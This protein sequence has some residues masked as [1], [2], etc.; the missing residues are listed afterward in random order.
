MR[1]RKITPLYVYTVFLLLSIYTTHNPNDPKPSFPLWARIGQPRQNRHPTHN[2]IDP[3]K[4]QL[5]AQ[6]QSDVKLHSR[7]LLRIT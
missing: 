2:P 7:Q 5:D 3:T 4:I 6:L 1:Y